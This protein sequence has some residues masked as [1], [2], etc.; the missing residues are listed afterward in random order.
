MH[1]RLDEVAGA[2]ARG[3]HL[4]SLGL[5]IDLDADILDVRL[6]G[7]LI[8]LHDV[9]TDTAFFLRQT[10][11]DNVTAFELLFAANTAN[12]AHC[13]PLLPT[14]RIGITDRTRYIKIY[15]LQKNGGLTGARTRDS[16]LKR[17][18]LYRL[19][20]QPIRFCGEPNN[21]FKILPFGKIANPHLNF[22]KISC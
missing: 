5:T 9:Q 20:Y 22:F 17:A 18:V 16:R 3:A 1:L 2:D 8:G 12:V 14:P 13:E 4:D 10:A 15:S 11:A 6:K 21:A 19:S 7:A